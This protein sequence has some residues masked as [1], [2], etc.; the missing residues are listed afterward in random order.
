[1]NDGP[2]IY[3]K[4]DDNKYAGLLANA[5]GG[6][7]E[8]VTLFYIP[9]TAAYI[10]RPGSLLNGATKQIE[11]LK[12]D[13]HNL[14]IRRVFR[15]IW[16]NATDSHLTDVEVTGFRDY[17]VRI[18]Q[19]QAGGAVQF[20][21]IHVYGGGMSAADNTSTIEGYGGMPAGVDSAAI[22]I[23]GDNNHGVDC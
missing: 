3:N 20:A 16:M 14:F 19:Y 22:W 7:L 9:G 21:R 15:G 18:G 2:N 11:R 23:D 10:A 6:M 5:T 12:W 17:G 4:T 1:V 8:N 13:V